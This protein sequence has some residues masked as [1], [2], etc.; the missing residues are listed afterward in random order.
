MQLARQ[1]ARVAKPGRVMERNG[2]IVGRGLMDVK[3]G[4]AAHARQRMQAA[5]N[6]KGCTH[7]S[8]AFVS[9]LNEAHGM[10]RCKSVLT[11][12]PITGCLN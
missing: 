9:I 2:K 1:F 10:V 11:H 7:W 4:A 5:D 8:T 6:A 3:R 12:C